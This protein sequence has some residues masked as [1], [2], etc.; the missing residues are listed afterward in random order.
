MIGVSGSIFRGSGFGVLDL[1]FRGSRFLVQGS[2]FRIE[3]LGFQVLGFAFWVRCVE[4]RGFGSGYCFG[5]GF[6]V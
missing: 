4:V 6:R 3:V 5:S 1:V 2:W